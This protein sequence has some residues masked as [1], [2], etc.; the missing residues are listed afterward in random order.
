MYANLAIN[1]MKINPQKGSPEYQPLGKGLHLFVMR[2]LKS[3]S[4]SHRALYL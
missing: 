2:M 3:I 4:I 1:Y